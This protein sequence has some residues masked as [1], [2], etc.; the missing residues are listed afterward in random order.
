MEG[1]EVQ[2]Q[3]RR[4]KEYKRR[5]RLNHE[6]AE[7]V[8]GRNISAVLVI[9][10]ILSSFSALVTILP[11]NVRA[12]TLF[13]GGG[14]A[15]NYTT[16]QSAIDAAGWGDTIFVYSGTYYEDIEVNESVSLVGED[17]DIT[18]IE[19]GTYPAVVN[20]TADDVS[21]S[22]FRIV[23]NGPERWI[24]GLL[25]KSVE[26]CS[27]T[28]NN[29]SSNQG[30]GIQFAQSQNNTIHNN[31]VSRST[32]GIEMTQSNHNVLTNNTIMNLRD[33]ITLTYSTDNILSNNIMSNNDVGI[34]IYYSTYS[35]LTNNTMLNDGIR[36]GGSFLDEWNS[37]V[38][39]IDNTVNGRPI[40]YWKNATGGV[41]PSDAGQIILANTTDVN[42]QDMSLSDVQIGISLGYTSRIGIS[43]VTFPNVW[44]GVDVYLSDNV[45]IENCTIP[46]AWTGVLL[47]D[48]VNNTVANNTI[49]HDWI[50]LLILG[51]RDSRITGNVLQGQRY[52]IRSSSA[53][54]NQISHNTIS[55]TGYGMELSSGSY[56][57]NISHNIISSCSEYGIQVRVG[58]HWN[59]IANNT[60]SASG[61]Y[62]AHIGGS[63]YNR[64]YH[65][66]FL[67]NVQSAYDDTD[68]NQWDNG[69][70]SG[71]NY[72]S[73]Y[74][75]FDIYRGPRQDIPGNDGIGDTP[76]SIDAD[77]RDRYPLV[78]PG[79]DYVSP[80]KNITAILSGPNHENVT[81]LWEPSPHEATGQ[82]RNYTVFRGSI[83]HVSG[84]SYQ[85]IG[86]VPNG[87]YSYVDAY[88][89]DVNIFP[90]FYIV[91]AVNLTN[92]VSCGDNQAGKMR[93]VLQKGLNLVS[94]PFIPVDEN[95][96]TV[97]QTVA[98]DSAW[99]FDS[100]SQEWLS[101]TDSKPYIK[102]L[103]HVK[104]TMGIWVNVTETSNFTVAGAV[105]STTSVPLKAGW[106][107]VGHPF[108]TSG[109]AVL[110][111]KQN[112]QAKRIE[113]FDP[114]PPYSLRAMADGEFLTPLFG[115]WI[116]VKSDTVWSIE[117]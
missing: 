58:S 104:R 114:V 43:N 34:S 17:R 78:S 56:W 87:T 10:V 93:R 77:S 8:R 65:N 115:Y 57:N 37:H 33:G 36:I 46:D 106:N 45:T 53:R 54:Y 13:V 79:A 49:S 32:E 63:W 42:V 73:D 85:Y 25:F 81:V 52:G 84:I 75:G 88:A 7:C 91:C 51:V 21:V 44:L 28:N 12:T 2:F 89:G 62:G 39:G 9:L 29:I 95:I 4:R 68:L 31:I 27:V 3:G 60:I 111:L 24:R 113:G 109:I 41:V 61:I 69:Y 18:T 6:G 117:N 35:I 82:V 11:E 74:S 14:G 80:P 96:G 59:T 26:R 92:N 20:V 105:P 22:G 116:E 38:I 83:Y 71:G 110:E 107:L 70:P 30:F 90:Y 50:G 19:G 86:D 108:S 100:F 55:N 112:L 94:M 66:R 98:Y 40:R 101:I 76:Y 47:N 23:Y 67:S 72:W 15:G 97:L 1:L 102:G 5:F 48:C 103:E 64:I 16:I 99:H